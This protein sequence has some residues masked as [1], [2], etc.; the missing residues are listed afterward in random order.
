M[1]R[2]PDVERSS[3]AREAYVAGW[4]AILEL[5]R[6]G[7]SWSGHER[8]CAFLSCGGETFA[9]VSA[10]SGLDFADDGRALAVVDWDQD[11]DLDLW[12]HNRTGPRLRLMINRSER[13]G[14]G[15]SVAF[16]LQGTRVNRDAIGAR[17]EVELADGRRRIE[18][19]YAGDGFLSQSSKWLH[20]GLG[21]EDRIESVAVRWPGG[22]RE[23]FAGVEA[24]GR[25]R[26]V[27]GEGIARPLPP[28]APV[29]LAAAPQEPAR[30]PAAAERL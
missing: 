28:R 14:G 1:S 27:E 10:A 17:V 26:L 5:L 6:Q 21:R 11:G 9:D 25:Y 23:S 18:T 12:L 2:S 4:Q 15:R 24:G 8:N 7:R 22:R 19:L 13:Y 3:D 29:R 16:R 20:V 30:E